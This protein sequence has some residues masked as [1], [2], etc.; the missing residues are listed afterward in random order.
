MGLEVFLCLK[1]I[2]EVVWDIV[3]DDISVSHIGLLM[4]DVLEDVLLVVPA[5]VGV[6]ILMRVPR[7]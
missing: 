3:E 1:E 4:E 6:L 7:Q 2:V 5:D